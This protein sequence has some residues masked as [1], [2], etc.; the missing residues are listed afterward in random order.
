MTIKGIVIREKRNRNREIPPS[1]AAN[2]PYV[3]KNSFTATEK[4]CNALLPPFGL[5]L[6]RQQENYTSLK[7]IRKIIP[8]C[9][10]YD[11]DYNTK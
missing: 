8:P 10:E 11:G 5:V 6:D 3:N 2:S 7:I 4:S 9:L 1:Q